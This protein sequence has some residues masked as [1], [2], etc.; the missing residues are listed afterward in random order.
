MKRNVGEY[1]PKPRVTPAQMEMLRKMNKAGGTIPIDS[2]RLF[3]VG[4]LVR[5]GL[6]KGDMGG[7]IVLTEEGRRALR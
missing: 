5:K 7:H 6:A 1:Y 2:T 4:S 3:T